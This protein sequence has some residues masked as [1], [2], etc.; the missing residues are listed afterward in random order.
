MVDFGAFL[1]QIQQQADDLEQQ[2][3]AAGEPPLAEMVPNAIVPGDLGPIGGGPAAPPPPPPEVSDLTPPPPPAAPADNGSDPWSSQFGDP[4]KDWK[5]GNEIGPGLSNIFKNGGGLAGM[6]NGAL[7]A[8]QN[9]ANNP[10]FRDNKPLQAM[11]ADG[12]I[13]PD[14]FTKYAQDQTVVRASLAYN[15][16]GQ[17]GNYQTFESGRNAWSPVSG[18]ASGLIPT[19]LP[20]AQQ[21][22]GRVYD[23][24]TPVWWNDRAGQAFL[25]PP[26][27]SPYADQIGVQVPTG[28]KSNVPP[29][30]PV[31]GRSGGYSRGGPQ[32]PQRPQGPQGPSA[33]GL[34]SFGQG[35]SG[36]QVAGK[37]GLTIQDE[38]GNP[39]VTIGPNQPF[40]KYADGTYSITD[41]NGRKTFFDEN[42]KVIYQ[43]DTPTA[44]RYSSEQDTQLPPVQQGTPVRQQPAPPPPAN[45]TYIPTAGTAEAPPPPLIYTSTEGRP[46]PLYG[47][48]GP[49]RQ[50]PPVNWNSDNADLYG[51]F[52]PPRR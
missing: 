8:F 41:V 13:T 44:S 12:S 19:E 38:Q 35:Q 49:P 33:A 46:N 2:A 21:V 1:D 11:A 23:A 36:I 9:A 16:K 20:V 26:Q 34:G 40:T 15:D 18:G 50:F 45:T 48:F 39:A 28:F 32:G 24:G 51:Q 22:D 42:G 43:E 5:T 25:R 17:L 37:N 3:N 6:L 10:A 29:P 52:G 30:P 7:G 27:D 4:N 47:Q 31:G 14:E